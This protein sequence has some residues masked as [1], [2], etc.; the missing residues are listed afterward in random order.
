MNTAQKQTAQI[1]SFADYLSDHPDK[2]TRTDRRLDQSDFI[3]EVHHIERNEQLLQ[4]LHE[5]TLLINKM[6]E[7][8][9]RYRAKCMVFSVTAGRH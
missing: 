4:M 5:Q 2:L 3:N 8:L 1:V 7:D 9:K 6:R